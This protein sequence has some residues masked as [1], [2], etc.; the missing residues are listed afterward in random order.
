MNPKVSSKLVFEPAYRRGLE[1]LE[2]GF[3][4]LYLLSNF[5]FV[6]GNYTTL[7]G[8]RKWGQNRIYPRMLT[9]G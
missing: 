8:C 3:Q 4:G 1:G 7:G 2:T 6:I 5:A 9:G